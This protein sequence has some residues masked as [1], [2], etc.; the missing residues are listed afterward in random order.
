M[1]DTESVLPGSY[2]YWV[3]PECWVDPGPPRM[4][5]PPGAE[6]VV[7]MVGSG[8]VPPNL[9]R[10]GPSGVVVVNNT[11][12]MIDAGEGVFR[13]LVRVAGCHDG[14][15]ADAI[16]PSKM[17]RLFLSHLH[18]DHTVGL[19]SLMLLPWA[20][21]RE[22]PLEIHGAV[23]VGRLAAGLMEAY[24]GD[25]GERMRGPEG[26]TKNK[27]GWRLVAHEVAEPG[28]VYKDDNIEVECFHH[29]HGG[30]VQ[31]FG[32]KFTTADRVVVW[33]GDGQVSDSFAEAAQ[34]ADLVF[35]EL[36]SVET[37]DNATWGGATDEEKEET[38]WAYH[39]KPTKLARLA[40][41]A[42]VKTLVLHH[43]CNYSDPFDPE[44]LLNE[45]KKHYAGNVI[46]A[47]DADIF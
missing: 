39:M 11:P 14:L 46:S 5:A 45:M 23:G 28:P 18:S 31:N 32:Y 47:R 44:A 42:N 8:T 6:T 27:T 34:G 10:R 29:P 36:A 30:F 9:F 26:T 38:M 17:T 41:E 13:G 35:S 16:V 24:H 4:L 19:P 1:K 20:Y 43:E 2:S 3:P 15:L 40:T 7:A 37:V 12:Y 21:L 33:A 22:D 25:L